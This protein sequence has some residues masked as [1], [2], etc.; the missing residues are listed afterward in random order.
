VHHNPGDELVR[1]DKYFKMKDGSI[2]EPTFYLGAKLKKTVLPN[3]V[4]AW[5]MSSSKYVNDAVHNVR[6]YLV[7]I[8][9]GQTLK[10][11][12]TAPF[13]VDYCPEMDTTLEL[14]PAM[15][16]YYQTHIG[17]LRWCVELGR[18]Y[19]VT[20]VSLLSSH[21][22]LPREGHLD[23]VFHLFAHLTNNHN[24]RVVFDPTYP[25]IDEDAFVT[26]EWKAMYGD[27]KEALPPDAPLLGKEVDL[28]VYVN[29]N[30][31]RE[32]F[33]RRSW[34]GFVIYLNMAPVV[35]FSKQQPTVESS[36]FG[37][38]FV[39]MKNGIETVR[40]LRYKLRMMGVPL[41]GPCYVYGDNMSVI[42][43]TQR[44]KSML[45]KKSNSMC[46]HVARESAAMGE[47]IMAHVRSENN[48]ADICTKVIPVGMKRRHLVGMLLFDICD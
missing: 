38:A 35:W 47:C 36:V 46:Y 20:E 34:T 40:G 8:D 9:G 45:K 27:V 6:E 31:T 3:G 28:R 13:P 16:N 5:G 19:I 12:A 17:V 33:T 42:H 23:T 29:S 44:P 10:K 32:K 15:A 24:A 4:I 11:K 25:V 26:A 18:I 39:G 37:A 14:S 48:P 7:T 43:N 22:C 30:H 41:S 2:Q 21:M 1:I